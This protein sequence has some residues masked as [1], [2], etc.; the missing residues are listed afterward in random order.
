VGWSVLSWR[1][2]PPNSGFGLGRL[3]LDCHQTA[4]AGAIDM[5]SAQRSA[6]LTIYANLDPVNSQG[7]NP[8]IDPERGRQRSAFYARV[9][10][11]AG[12]DQPVI[13]S[14]SQDPASLSSEVSGALRGLG[15]GRA[16]GPGT[17]VGPD[18]VLDAE[19]IEALLALADR[20]TFGSAR[21]K[22]Q[23]ITSVGSQLGTETLAGFELEQLLGRIYDVVWDD[24]GSAY[25]ALAPRWHGLSA[26]PRTT[27]Q[28]PP[29]TTLDLVAQRPGRFGPDGGRDFQARIAGSPLGPG[30]RCD[31]RLVPV[32][33]NGDGEYACHVRTVVEP[34]TWPPVPP[35]TTEAHFLDTLLNPEMWPDRSDFWCKVDPVVGSDPIQ[36]MIHGQ[37]DAAKPLPEPAGYQFG[38]TL[39][40]GTLSGSGA[41]CPRSFVEKVYSCPNGLFGGITLAFAD[42]RVVGP[43][44]GDA[45]YYLEYRLHDDGIVPLAYDDGTIHVSVR[46]G[47][48][49]FSTTKLLYARQDENIN[50][51]EALAEFV[52]VSGWG[53]MTRKFLLGS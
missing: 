15:E 18:A 1:A 3:V 42:S 45:D 8:R 5:V 11:L 35:Y 25:R 39:A 9:N 43:R 21:N 46:S 52:E 17:P 30:V 14:E 44:T 36:T 19:L 34:V 32:E 51:V 10:E 6:L 24:G 27:S 23:F 22:G 26:P 29:L 2:T 13:R 12:G 38:S 16:D 50:Q 47:V 7:V 4:A 41:Q 40:S 33:I 28:A 53:E 37:I 49:R 31:G 20:Y 48:A